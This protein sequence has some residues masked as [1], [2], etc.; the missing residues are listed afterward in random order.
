M[1][2]QT[3]SWE[4]VS[5]CENRTDDNALLCNFPKEKND[6][7]IPALYQIA[8]TTRLMIYDETAK[9]TKGSV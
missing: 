8:V 1:E 4:S 6:Q 5:E 2:R 7:K 3:K 9:G